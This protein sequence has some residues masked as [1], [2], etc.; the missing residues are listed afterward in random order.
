MSQRAEQ[1]HATPWTGVI[2]LTG[3]GSGFL[4]E[5]LSTPGASASILETRVPYAQAAL[6][7]LLGRAPEQAC[8]ST[9]ARQLAMAAFQRAQTLAPASQLYGFGCT[10]SL[11]TNREKKGEHRA[12]WCIQTHTATY[13]FSAAFSSDRAAEESELIDHL[14]QS[15]S[16]ALMEG[17]PPSDL[18]H[19]HHGPLEHFRPLLHS[20][21]YRTSTQPHDGLLILPGSFNPLHDGHRAIM[22][23]GEEVTGKQG[24]YELAVNNADKPS[25]DFLTLK[26]RIDQFE[27]EPLWLTN[28]PTYAEKAQLFPGA[29]FL[30]GVDT[31]E[32]IGQQKFYQDRA[33]LM[34][35]AIQMFHDF[36]IRFLV[37][38]R[39]MGKFVR[40]SDLALPKELTTL[41]QAAPDEFRMDISSTQLRSPNQ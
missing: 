1:F 41:C 5:L 13:D 4:S 36:E 6:E 26:A 34:T 39:Q 21:P 10:A 28:T 16:Y 40:L 22:A 32:R 14:W 2:Y 30:L 23:A 18:T 9:T 19:E 38:P 37:F 17:D 12:H 24:A 11:A 33:D 20:D 25:I 35:A 8:S 31:M 15:L 3:G 7:E 27:S 29:T